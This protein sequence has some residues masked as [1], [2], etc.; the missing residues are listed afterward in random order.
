MNVTL[1]STGPSPPFKGFLLRA[2]TQV[3]NQGHFN[4]NPNDPYHQLTCSQTQTAI[5]HSD[6]HPKFMVTLT[7]VIL[8]PGPKL[9]FEA[10]VGSLLKIQSIQL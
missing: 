8:I 7:W 4:L 3:P 6:T 2:Q 1:T 10:T 5:T 9:N